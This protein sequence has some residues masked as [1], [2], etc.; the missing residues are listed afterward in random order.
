[1]MAE[2]SDDDEVVEETA[3]IYTIPAGRLE[4][5]MMNHTRRG[6]A[7]IFNH[8]T[9]VKSKDRYG[10][11]ED[12]DNL[13]TRF[14]AL[15]F[16]VN[17]Y[18]DRRKKEVL[19]EISKAASDNHADADCFACIF[20][21]RGDEGEIKAYDDQI[22]IKKITDYFRGDK[23]RSLVGKPKIFIFLTITGSES[24]NAATGMRVEDSDAKSYTIPAGADF[25]VCYSVA[26]GSHSSQD[27]EC[28]SF[29]IQKLCETLKEHATTM[30]FTKLL[31][32][33]NQKVSQCNINMKNEMPCFTSMLTKTLYFSKTSPPMEYQ[34]NHDRRGLAL[35]F[36][37]EDF[38]NP[39]K[40]RRGT[41]KDRDI[42]RDRFQ[43]LGFEVQSYN[44]RKVAVVQ[45]KL[46]E[47]AAANH[48]DADCFV[49][50]FL[51]HGK[52]GKIEAFD[53]QIE[54]KEITDVFRGDECKSLVGKPKIFI[55][56]ACAGEKHENAVTGMAGDS[57]DDEVVEEAANIYTIPAGS[58]FIMCYSVAPG[59]FSYRDPN[60]GTFYIQDLCETL[61]QHG[62]TMEFTEILTLVN[63]KVSRRNAD[64]NNFKNKKQMPCFTSMLTKKLY[65]RSK[66][67]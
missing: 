40:K 60:S 20:L 6:K 34:M 50:I 61:K 3:N 26:P 31:T 4:E 27:V 13:I 39:D 17:S 59:F 49:C 54:I 43:E 52:E 19:E 62:P 32:L 41:N 18:N 57:D 9:F 30:E 42:L 11:N 28:R 55:F 14:Q 24:E 25:L 2:D 10:T 5:Y 46:R 36:N 63:M 47:A 23:C 35:I 56:Q 16:E 66:K 1:M 58:D 65:F 45:E 67:Q 22:E 38:A 29:Y 15:G 37:H 64:G 12:R 8:E 51:S 48:K 21:T 7:L 44:D 53:N 33:V